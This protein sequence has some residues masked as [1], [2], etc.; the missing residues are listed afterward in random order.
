MNFIKNEPTQN[1]K[2]LSF[3][4]FLQ[5]ELDGTSAFMTWTDVSSGDAPPAKGDLC[6]LTACFQYRD[7]KNPWRAALVT[8]LN[9]DTN[10]PIFYH[11]MLETCGKIGE[12]YVNKRR[13]GKWTADGEGG[14]I[15]LKSLSQASAGKVIGATAASITGITNGKNWAV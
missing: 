14:E 13:R 12:K 1:Q 8:P 5:N 3:I 6:R 4:G 11:P 15:C 9:V 2:I 10:E 7:A